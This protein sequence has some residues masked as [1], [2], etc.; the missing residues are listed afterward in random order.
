MMAS[1]T[2]GGPLVGDSC[3][4]RA[5]HGHKDP[6][7]FYF[8]YKDPI[9]FYFIFRDPIVFLFSYGMPQIKHATKQDLILA[10]M[11][12]KCIHELCSLLY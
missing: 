11:H 7:D 10:L 5:Q 6:V 9:I 3:G 2:G 4:A 8:L 12:V 1:L